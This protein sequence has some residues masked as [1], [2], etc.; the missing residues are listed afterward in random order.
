MKVRFL[1]SWCLQTKLKWFFLKEEIKSFRIIESS[2]LSCENLEKMVLK[3][4]WGQSRF[5]QQRRQRSKVFENS[6]FNYIVICREEA[7]S[8]FWEDEVK[9]QKFFQLKSVIG[10]VL[11][12]RVASILR[13][14]TSVMR[15]WTATFAFLHIFVIINNNSE[16]KLEVILRP[17]MNVQSVS[18][19]RFWNFFNNKFERIFLETKAKDS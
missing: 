5:L 17:K 16:H 1:A 15:V 11:G 18:E 12:N 2:S 8:I 4:H 14:K 6:N 3:Q 13:S 10:D 9:P 7:K 19:P